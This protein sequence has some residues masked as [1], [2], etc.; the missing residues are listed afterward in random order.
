MIYDFVDQIE[1]N[2]VDE[3]EMNFDLADQNREINGAMYITIFDIRPYT[4]KG[5][6]L[7]NLFFSSYLQTIFISEVVPLIPYGVHA[8][9]RFPIRM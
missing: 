3:I 9:C 7:K 1:M 8:G 6:R 4:I 5:P 2:F